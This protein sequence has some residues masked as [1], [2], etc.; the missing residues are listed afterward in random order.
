M[1]DCYYCELNAIHPFHDDGSIADPL[2][3]EDIGGGW[4]TQKVVNNR[5]LEC[6][7]GRCICDETERKR[8][9]RVDS[10]R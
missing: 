3:C 4:E 2:L 10:P 6:A 5:E 8:D 7:S 9:A 1:S